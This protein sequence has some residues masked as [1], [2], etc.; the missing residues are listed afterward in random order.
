[1]PKPEHPTDA[2]LRIEAYYDAV[3]RSAAR[4]EEWPPLR[5][6]AQRGAGWPYYARPALGA[7]AR[8][9]FLPEHV[10]RVRQRQRE[11]GLPESFEW[12]H[13]IVPGLRAAVE[14]AGLSVHT[15]P[16]MVLDSTARVRPAPPAGV[17]VSLVSPDL[18]DDELRRIGA[19]APVGFAAPGTSAGPAGLEALAT[20]SA[21]TSAEQL[22]DRRDRLRRGVTVMAVA[23]TAEG[24]VATGSHQ[25]VA[26]VS[27]IVGVAT[28]PAYR[29]RGIGAA[30]V[31]LLIEDA[32]RRGAQ[33]IFLTAGDDAIARVY[34]RLGF[35]QIATGCIAE[36]PE[37]A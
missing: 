34:H 30:V 16:L 12:T 35:R 14:A 28:L 21:S 1:M 6:F 37:P 31:D 5:L 27:E 11:L 20:E 3:P 33:T 17:S 2:L 22:A 26:E 8:T 15:Y 18:P 29:R 13:E 23:H 9:V 19:V 32:L 25:P 10:T 4:V 36:P 7:D 24:P